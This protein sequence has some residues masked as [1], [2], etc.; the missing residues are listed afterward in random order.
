[1]ASVSRPCVA[2]A[3][4]AVVGTINDA[5]Y[6]GIA[7]GTLII[8]KAAQSITFPAPGNKTYGA[9]A[10][11]L[12]GSATSGLAVAFS[13][14]SGPATIAGRTVT[15]TGAGT[16]TLEGSQAGNANYNAATSVDHSFT[17]VKALVTA[18]ADDKSKAQGA[19]NPILTVSYSGFVNGDTVAALDSL[20]TASTT[21]TTSSR[22]GSYPITLTGGVDNNYAFKLLN[23]TLTVTAGTT[24][25]AF[26][27]KLFV[28]VL[29]REP[30]A[31]E[32]N[33]YSAELAGGRSRAAVLGE[34]LDT[35]EYR[36]RQIEPTI[37]LYSAALGRSPD[38]DALRD[39]SDVLRSGVLTIA[40]AA[41]QFAGGAEFQQRYG[42]LDNKEYVQQLYRN[43]PG[44]EVDAA[45]QAAWVSQ[46]DAG[47]SR[48]AVLVGLAESDEFKTAVA[49]QVE[50]LRLH[51]LL[52]H[53]M[54]A[55]A[56]LQDFLLSG[57]H[58][59]DARLSQ[60]GPTQAADDFAARDDRLRDDL[61]AA[62]TF[63]QGNPSQ[64]GD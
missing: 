43:A 1:M 57:D 31:G 45:D 29:D 41:D 18:K 50:I 52:L 35:S 11:T 55:A 17:V 39:W 4:Y 33:S 14:V 32:L 3:S 34:L 61:L 38:Y 28:D 24:T 40:E 16:V 25:Q 48:G 51:F 19:T 8:A 49:D 63:I 10:F 59:V 44:R 60:S 15:L 12:S 22:V 27:K 58:S 6:Q 13:V 53:R 26:L 20:P 37:R 5:N 54:P 46:L 56:E 9:A 30:D 62:P 64:G 2:L 7:S 42:A 47:A 21:A 36:Q 23:G